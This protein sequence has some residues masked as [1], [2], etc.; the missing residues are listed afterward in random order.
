MLRSEVFMRQDLEAIL[1]ALA[2]TAAVSSSGSESPHA[3]AYRRGFAAAIAA[4]AVAIHADVRGPA[5]SGI[6][7]M[8]IE[9]WTLTQSR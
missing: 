9:R 3:A 5:R 7:G 6:T 8:E 2:L 4:M 1:Q